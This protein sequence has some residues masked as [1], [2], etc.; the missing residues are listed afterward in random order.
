MKSALIPFLR[1]RENRVHNLGSSIHA[2]EN[3]L[4]QNLVQNAIAQLKT[5][6]MVSVIESELNNS[7]RLSAHRI[8][9]PHPDTHDQKAIR[10]YQQLQ[11]GS[12]PINPQNSKQ[13]PKLASKRQP[14]SGQATDLHSF[15]MLQ[16]RIQPDNSEP[17]AP[18]ARPST[19]AWS[20][21]SNSR[22]HRPPSQKI[23]QAG[24]PAAEQPSE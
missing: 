4:R 21:R 19:I 10:H 11:E 12:R 2:S 3:P 22:N 1:N 15:E 14:T 18:R 13:L 23:A 5:T 17:P 9:G 24:A 6:T 16:S 8:Q 7:K 20:L